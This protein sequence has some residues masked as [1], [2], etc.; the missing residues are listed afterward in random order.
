MPDIELTR[1]EYERYINEGYCPC[2][3]PH[4]EHPEM[5]IQDMWTWQEEM[6]AWDIYDRKM[7]EIA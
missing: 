3:F 5:T 2:C 1:K 4:W 7:D 6:N